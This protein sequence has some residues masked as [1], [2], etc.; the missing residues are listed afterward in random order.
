MLSQERW[1]DI[2]ELHAAGLS[3][4]AIARQ[5]GHSR[6]TVSRVL[7]ERAPSP[8]SAPARPSRLDPFKAYI[9]SRYEA[10]GLSCVR[11]LE[12]IRP[13]GY[14]GSIDILRRYVHGLA[15]QQHASARATVR[16]E[17]PPGA[18]GQVDWASCGKLQTGENVYAFVMV[19]G[20]SRMSYIEFTTSMNLPTLLRCHMKA[21]EYLGGIPSAILYDNMKQ[22]RLGPA[23]LNPQFVDFAGHYGFTVKT[24][25]PYR[26]R[27]KGKVERLV[28]YVKDNFLAGREFADLADINAQGH[29]W[30]RQTANVRVHATTNRKP[31]DLLEEEQERLIPTHTVTAYQ[32]CE[33][34]PRKVATEGFVR[35]FGSRYSV[36][37]AYI[38]RD[39][40]VC[41][42][43]HKVVVHCVRDAA[44]NALGPVIAEHD[45]ATSA[46]Q[47]VADKSHIAQLW[48]ATMA[49][50]S[51]S[52]RAGIALQWRRDDRAS[53]VQVRALSVYEEVAAP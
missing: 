49:H 8:Y 13:M 2:K 51:V 11:L 14:D 17:T 31:V 48:K 6:N 33:Q 42:F 22:V 45:R 20:F 52:V 18:Q 39:V 30:L 24:H 46:G 19:L 3:I 4:R 29:S 47:F 44:A 23:R 15:A 53:A 7:S 25:K 16:F 21:F 34:L 37:P 12:D 36:P 10:Y 50:E 5:T 41:A 32:I 38:E 43:E 26:P 35:A 28:D 40:I 9:K 27:T 1:M